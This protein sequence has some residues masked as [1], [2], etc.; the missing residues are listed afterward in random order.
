VGGLVISNTG[1]FPDIE[2]AEIARAMRTPG[3][4]EALVDSVS[5]EGFA[6]L[7]EAASGAFDERALDEYWKAF[8]TAEGRRG[9]LELYRSFNP[10]ELKPSSGCSRHSGCPR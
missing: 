1:F 8:T 3:Q 4:G 7:L 10:D 9:M 6:T 2:W 5:R